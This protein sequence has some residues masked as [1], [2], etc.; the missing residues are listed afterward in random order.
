MKR[1]RRT[2]L[3]LSILI[4][5]NSVMVCHGEE[6]ESGEIP[7]VETNAAEN[8]TPGQS[9]TYE[10]DSQKDTK[11]ITTAQKNN[12]EENLEEAMTI[13][14][15]G[16]EE[17]HAKDDS[18]KEHEEGNIEGE[19]DNS[20]VATEDYVPVE[21]NEPH[22]FGSVSSDIDNDVPYYKSEYSTYRELPSSYILDKEQY[23]MLRDQGSYGTCWAFAAIGLSEF[24]LISKNLA[25]R[26]LDLSE[27]QLAYFTYNS[28][29]DPLGG[30]LGDQNI[31]HNE[32]A[33]NKYLDVGGTYQY[34]IRRLAQWSG[35]AN[36][37]DV[38][39]TTDSINNVLTNGLS[40]EYAYSKD[41]AHLENA[42]VMS[43]KNNTDD[44]KAAIIDH[45]AVGVQYFHNSSAI[46]FAPNGDYTY[47]DTNAS[48][49]GH[50]VMIVGYDDTYSRDNFK[51]S[52]QPTKDGAWLIR[53]SW[54]DGYMS[55]FW[56]SYE[57]VS[58][59]DAAWVFEMNNSNGEDYYDNNYQLD[60][61]L[62][63][64]K[65]LY[66]YVRND[67]TCANIF[68]VQSNDQ[69]A[70][71]ELKA[72]S[73]SFT[74]TANVH[75]IIEIYTDLQSD[76]PY[77]GVKQESA[78][79]EGTTTYAGYYTIPLN[80][81]VNLKP[82]SRFAVL[83]TPDKYGL[84]MDYGYNTT[85]K[86]GTGYSWE[87]PITKYDG[88]SYVI[89]RDA[90]RETKWTLGNFCIKA[91]TTN[92]H[93]EIKDISNAVITLNDDF[94]VDQPS[95]TVTCDGEKLVQDTDYTMSYPFNSFK[96]KFKV[97]ITGVN[98]YSGSLYQVIQ[99]YSK[100]G[101][102]LNEYSLC[103]NGLIEMYFHFYLTDELKN[104]SGA[105]VLFDLPNGR[106]QKQYIKDTEYIEGLGYRFRCGLYASEM[107]QKVN[108]VFVNSKGEK[109]QKYSRSIEDY[110]KII[111][112]Q[113]TEA[114]KKVTP[115]L[116]RM[117]NYG[118]Y[119]QVMFH[120]N[121]D[122]MAYKDVKDA[123]A[124]EMNSINL[125]DLQ[126]YKFVKEGS[127]SAVVFK[128]YALVLKEATSIRVYFTFEDESALKDCEAYV[129]GNKVDIK[130][131]GRGYYVE[132]PAIA[133]NKLDVMH[134]VTCGDLEFK[135]SAL[136]WVR[137]ILSK[138]D[139]VEADTSNVAKSIYL[140][141][142]ESKA[143]FG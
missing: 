43:L 127:D 123:L 53:N 99:L 51:Q 35:V 34:A 46:R 64:E 8:S 81:T 58:L 117:L 92:N 136:S 22:Y 110:T 1:C 57:N 15:N 130:K 42:Y 121:E 113:D 120:N 86:D 10:S 72:V 105:Y 79:T 41:V 48:G 139:A 71:E 125:D 68:T 37:S 142:K 7:S 56:M 11:D 60:G 83:V 106:Q 30:T 18:V 77:S 135:V 4:S 65:V 118:G 97:T 40:D 47:F 17:A 143:Y 78:T 104:D 116:K 133:S 6:V 38:P 87:C 52:T 21:N 134:T 25:D 89:N 27:L 33:T 50:N 137:S 66:G 31:Y 2:A 26:S 14:Q 16:D 59:S 109:S 108:F 119:A 140:Y 5:F 62:F 132:A 131:D 32:N 82:G 91:F 111:F 85:G 29:V 61:G 102:S 103:L 74:E 49:Y 101:E 55:Y 39:Y 93:K 75:Y 128:E 80:D 45:G 44:V 23:P 24:D 96:S 122:D 138:G 70:S 100:V 107:T 84:D 76:N 67:M 95:I 19:T 28:A 115:L 36:E 129:D 20:E 114:Y 9:N 73:L 141:W 88:N 112:S 3:V 63:T 54:G 12:D 98:D 94:T 69:I 124:S 90:K 126:Q 13:E